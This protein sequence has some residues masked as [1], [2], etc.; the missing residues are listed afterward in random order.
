MLNHGVIF[1]V[2]VWIKKELIELINFESI[3]IEN[4]QNIARNN[5]LQVSKLPKL[6]VTDLWKYDDTEHNANHIIP[7]YYYLPVICWSLVDRYG[8]LESCK[9]QI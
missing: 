1:F 2:I 5:C 9:P 6:E 4:G 8:S 7:L 3:W